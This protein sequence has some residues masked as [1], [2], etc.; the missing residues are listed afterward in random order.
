MESNFGRFSG[1]RPTITA[2]ATLAWDPRRAT[3][4]RQELFNA[5]EILNRGDITL[6]RMRG[7]WAG[8]MGQPQFMPSSYLQF[9][10]D[11][12]ENGS[13]DIWT[14]TP[15]V[16]ASIANYLKGKGWVEGQ[17]WGREVSVSKTVAAIIATTVARR[18]GSCQATRDMSIALPLAEWQRL[19]VRTVSGG[20]LPNQPIAAS[21]VSGEKRHFLTYQNYDALLQYNCAHAYALSVAL[22]SDQIA[23]AP[24]PAKAPPHSSKPAPASRR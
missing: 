16:L 19:G 10:V 18:D 2:L 14:S 5:L 20:T 22:L 6:P 1:V 7:S 23:L 9:A 13:R 11:F 15:D 24:A 8:A 21:L 12:D 17:L 4:F 3:F